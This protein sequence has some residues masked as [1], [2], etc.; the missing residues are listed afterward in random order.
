MHVERLED[1]GDRTAA[2][3]S[4]KARGR[5]SGVELEGR[6]SALWTIRDGKAVRYEW[7]HDPNDA[8][9]ALSRIPDL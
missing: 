2:L 5:S 7:F 3:V 4:Y 9:D 1:A 6:E 8:F